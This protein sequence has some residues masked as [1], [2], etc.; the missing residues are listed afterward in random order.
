M[1]AHLPI[2]QIAK[3]LPSLFSFSR[4][5]D[6]PHVTVTVSFEDGSTIEA[7]TNSQYTFMIPWKL[8]GNDEHKSYDIAISRAVSGLMPKDS[9]NKERLIGNGFASELAQAVM[10]NIEPEWK[11]LGVEGRAGDALAALRRVYTVKSADINSYHNKEYGLSW[12]PKGPYETNLD[13]VLHKPAL[14]ENLSVQLILLYDQNKV[15]GVDDFLKTADN[16]ESLVLSVAW[17]NAFLRENPKLNAWLYFVHRKFVW[18]PCNAD[19]CTG[20]ESAW[21]GRSDRKGA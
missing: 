18:R 13:A 16:Y 7:K 11:M 21:P 14:P 17:L 10:R 6:Y 5:D 20:H 15:E 8:S 2:K 3:I 9:V 12:K 4:T 19:L 1:R